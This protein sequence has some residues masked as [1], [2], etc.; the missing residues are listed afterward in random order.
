MANRSMK[1]AAR[2][3]IPSFEGAVRDAQAIQPPNPASSYVELKRTWKT[4]DTIELSLPKLLR[5]EALPDNPHRAAIMWGPL[6]LAG[7]LG[8]EKRRSGFRDRGVSTNQPAVPVFLAADR[9][10]SG[11]VKPIEGKAGEFRTE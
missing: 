1:P 6:V 11:W 8:P 3:R 5:L 10:V 9:P 4:G 2:G 7:D